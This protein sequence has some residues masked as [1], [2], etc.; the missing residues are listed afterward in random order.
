MRHV[1]CRKAWL[2]RAATYLGTVLLLVACA[3]GTGGSEPRVSRA[4]ATSSPAASPGPDYPLWVPAS[5]A[6][7]RHLEPRTWSPVAS[8]AW[9]HRLLLV[10]WFTRLAGA[11]HVRY[12]LQ[13]L[14]HT[15][16]PVQLLARA[17][18]GTG[19]VRYATQLIPGPQSVA[20]TPTGVWVL[21]SAWITRNLEHLG[22]ETLYRFDPATLRLVSARRIGPPAGW[23]PNPALSAGADGELWLAA[24]S[25]ARLIRPVPWSVLRTVSVRHGRVAQLA[26][27]PDGRRV[28]V[29]VAVG[30]GAGTGRWLIQERDRASWA[31]LSTRTLPGYGYGVLISVAGSAVWV[32]TGVAHSGGVQL[33]S[34]DLH[35]VRLVLG[36]AEAAHG[37]EE[38][39][40]FDFGTEVTATVLG[41]AAWL[42][43][44]NALACLQP[45]TGRV[46]AEQPGDQRH[47]AALDQGPTVYDGNIYGLQFLG[48]GVPGEGLVEVH[49]PAVCAG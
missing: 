49:P 48:G 42:T 28:Y 24:G 41:G 27:T 34:G 3:R 23:T 11:G 15:P 25:T 14:P 22:P 33:L 6:L 45:A 46:L 2:R 43:A 19:D 13:E 44:M 29:V 21:G 26:F 1:T 12:L 35:A 39:H 38:K 10:G 7:P 18:L 20:V 16:Y 36:A 5:V 30:S 4:H 37:P 9:S 32:S 17:D 47:G 31:L 40:F 8:Q